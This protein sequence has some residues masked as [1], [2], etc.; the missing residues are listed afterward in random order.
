[1]NL[2]FRQGIARYQTDVYATPTFL[3]KSAP[4]GE[5]IDLIV[6]PDPTIIIFAHKAATYV[7][8]ESQTVENAWGPFPVGASTKYLYWDVNLLD[9]SLTH[10]YTSVGPVTSSEAPPQPAIDQHWYDTVNHVM[11]VWS[12][13]K[14]LEKLRVFAATYSSTAVIV[15]QTLGSQVGETGSFEAGNLV[16]DAFNK[17]L[18]QSDGSFV[19]SSTELSI[20]NAASTK[21]KFDAEIVAG[22]ADEAIPKFSWVQVRP[23][24]RLILGRSDDWRSRVAGLVTEDLYQS[25]IGVV[26]T[27]G[28]VRNDQWNW[29]A[30]KVGRPVFCSPDGVVQLDPPQS[31]TSQI[32]GFVYDTDSIHV[33]IKQATILTDI[34]NEVDAS[35]APQNL[36][37]V[38]DFVTVSP[39]GTVPF[40][41]NFISTSLHNP[42]TVQWDFTNSGTWNSTGT[43]VTH[44]YT[45][46]GT[47]TVKVRATNTFGMDEEIKVGFITA[48]APDPG[49]L[50]T[51]LG[52]QLGGPIQMDKNSTASISILITNDGNLGATL[53]RRLVTVRDID[54]GRFTFSELPS[55]TKQTRIENATV[56][57]F[58]SIS[59]MPPGSSIPLSFKITAPD[60]KGMLL[61][62]A[63]VVSPEEDSTLRDNTSELYVKVR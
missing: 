15:P 40:T 19:T 8:E 37:P 21:V 28:L 32:C 6:S 10:G 5:Y 63:M 47:Y 38:A 50:K 26:T 2:T 48:N 53:V 46:P 7:V 35:P 16:F 17:P 49:P 43:Q 33:E 62:L 60:K 31:G 3:R 23:N 59:S 34:T 42:T 51:N 25:E 18:R 30:D 44:V 52:I 1:M 58:Q 36:A 20:V 12:G 41:V 55:M 54:G 56:L 29:P 11:K 45:E 13:L 4:S 57:S 61:L 22:M 24:R 27:G 14:W 9:A 39:I